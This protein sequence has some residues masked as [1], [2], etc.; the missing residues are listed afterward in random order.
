EVEGSGALLEQLERQRPQMVQP[1]LIHG[2]F[3]MDNVLLVEGKVSGIVDWAWGAWGDPRYDLA[4]AIRPKENLFQTSEDIQAFLD[5]Y[6]TAAL[7][8]E[9]YDYFVSLYEF[10]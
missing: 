9:E 8:K 7:S 6:G 1:T 10:F 5:G 2:D 4:L 3:A